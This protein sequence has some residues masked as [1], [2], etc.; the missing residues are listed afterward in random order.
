MRTISERIQSPRKNTYFSKRVFL[1]KTPFRA[2]VP[3]VDGVPTLALCLPR[4]LFCWGVEYGGG[5]RD[6]A[7]SQSKGID[8]DWEGKESGDGWKEG[9]GRVL[10]G[11]IGRPA[12]PAGDAGPD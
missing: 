2:G 11:V 7:A 12:E 1:R 9:R 8:E 5:C 10:R 3:V 6:L 4:D